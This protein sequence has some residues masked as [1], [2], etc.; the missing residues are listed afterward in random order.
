MNNKNTRLF[1]KNVYRE[2]EWEKGK[3][4]AYSQIEL[5]FNERKVNKEIAFERFCKFERKPECRRAACACRAY[6]AY[7]T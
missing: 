5:N 6:C 2:R 3:V 7:D 4:R 1:V